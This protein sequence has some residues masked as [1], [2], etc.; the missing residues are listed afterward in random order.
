MQTVIFNKD[1]FNKELYNHLQTNTTEKFHKELKKFLKLN[2]ISGNTL[3]KRKQRAFLQYVVGAA[4]D[5]NF[6]KYITY[7]LGADGR[8]FNLNQDQL[9][10]M[11]ECFGKVPLYL[12]VEKFQKK[13]LLTSSKLFHPN[14]KSCLTVMVHRYG[15]DK[16]WWT[17]KEIIERIQEE[18][19]DVEGFTEK[20]IEE[21]LNRHCVGIGVAPF[22][23]NRNETEGNYEYPIRLTD[24][25]NYVQGY[26]E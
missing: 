11:D 3:P 18:G 10:R 23:Y 21:C 14:E 20:K 16:K 24:L 6:S 19:G 26:T 9:D 8:K 25:I 17:A 5:P 7:T 13:L 1:Y 22:L 4:N 2:G 15:L 12:A